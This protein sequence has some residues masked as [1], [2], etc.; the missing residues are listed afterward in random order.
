MKLYAIK[1]VDSGKFLS[2]EVEGNYDGYYHREYFVLYDQSQSNKSIW[3]VNDRKLA[4]NVVNN[5]NTGYH[6]D[7]PEI[8]Y[9]HPDNEYEIVEFS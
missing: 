7:C 9:S 3:V 4:E 2:V 6:I 8:G 5:L 1:R